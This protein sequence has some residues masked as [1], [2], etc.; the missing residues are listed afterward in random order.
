MDEAIRVGQN[1]RLCNG[2]E[3]HMFPEEI[4]FKTNTLLK[5]AISP[6]GAFF[7]GCAFVL[8]FIKSSESAA[9]WVQ[10]IGS[11]GAIVGAFLVARQTHTLEQK[12]GKESELGIEIRAV[13]L[14]EGI[15]QEAHAALSTAY[16][17]AR[18]SS[19][20]PVSARRLESVHQALMLAITQ[21]VSEQALK[22]IL[23]TLKRVSNSCGFLQDAMLHN[24]VLR[25]TD[26]ENM[27]RFLDELIA[28]KATLS[29]IL[30]D[31]RDRRK[32]SR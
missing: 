7:V 26:L 13:L 30:N 18:N 12:A 25:Q 28:N 2:L 5:I 27:R 9:A 21:P 14:A 1:R 8:L 4:R 32:K 22:P 24:G 15:V 11:I 29:E 20:T 19:D 17:N 6:P 16:R 3:P 23:K 31:L 10:A